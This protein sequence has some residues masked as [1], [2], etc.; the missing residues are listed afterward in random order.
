MVTTCTIHH[1]GVILLCIAVYVFGA[2]KYTSQVAGWHFEGS[3]HHYA[4]APYQH[5]HRVIANFR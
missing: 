3:V 2:M 1:V 5:D 4:I